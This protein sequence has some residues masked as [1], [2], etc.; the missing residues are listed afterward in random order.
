MSIES[1]NLLKKFQILS[2]SEKG[3][4]EEIMR[5]MDKH[6][7][8]KG[9]ETL[10]LA[11]PWLSGPLA[12]WVYVCGGY[13]W[14]ESDNSL[15][16]LKHDEVMTTHWLQGC[17]HPNWRS[18]PSPWIPCLQLIPPTTAV[19]SHPMRYSLVSVNPNSTV[20]PFPPLL[21]FL[22]QKVSGMRTRKS[23]WLRDEDYHPSTAP[24]PWLSGLPRHP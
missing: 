2:H 19:L 11:T 13:K 3:I 1:E 22:I 24:P 17:K 14:E 18:T 6:G 9:I 8:W 20:L 4:L 5:A 21:G 10:H 23:D 15:M 7:P 12:D 16:G